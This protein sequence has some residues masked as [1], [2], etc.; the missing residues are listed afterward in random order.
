MSTEPE[1]KRKIRKPFVPPPPGVDVVMSVEDVAMLF[2]ITVNQVYE[3]NKNSKLV[4]HKVGKECRYLYSE[5]MTAFMNADTRIKDDP[6]SHKKYTVD[7]LPKCWPPPDRYG[8]GKP[9]EGKSRKK[10][11][12]G[13]SE[14]V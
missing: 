12:E 1:G 5:V 9:R 6:T 7:E 3:H 2:D 13:E 4:V 14:P 10:A 8:D 11:A